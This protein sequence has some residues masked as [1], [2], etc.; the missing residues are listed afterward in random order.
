[1][2]FIR[3]HPIRVTHAFLLTYL[4]HVASTVIAIAIQ[5]QDGNGGSGNSLE[6]ATILMSNND[7]LE[8]DLV[9]DG[10][11]H[12]VDI[13]PS[14]AVSEAFV[15]TSLSNM[16][17]FFWRPSTGSHQT[18]P[19]K[20]FISR[21]FS[22]VEPLNQNLAP[23]FIFPR[24]WLHNAQRLYYYDGSE[25]TAHE[26]TFTLYIESEDREM[27]ELVRLYNPRSEELVELKLSETHPHLA[28][29]AARVSLVGR[30]AVPPVDASPRESST[31]RD[32]MVL[33]YPQCF[34]LP[35]GPYDLREFYFSEDV[36]KVTILTDVYLSPADRI[37]KI[38][39]TDR[40][41]V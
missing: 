18:W 10:N 41:R 23:G 22:T 19:N 28:N 26:D 5:G 36:L 40:F 20:Q 39:C 31:Q 1:M 8:I 27:G 2:K 24:K 7:P 6:K 37:E 13:E 21:A 15:L 25:D 34:F 16:K 4:L 11:L 33:G 14:I 17:F 9:Q 3:I 29:K 32:P 30:P 38:V 12:Y 35:D